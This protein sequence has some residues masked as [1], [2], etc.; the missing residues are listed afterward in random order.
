MTTA[1]ATT[2]LA[3]LALHFIS[4][5][6]DDFGCKSETLMMSGKLNTNKQCTREMAACNF[7]PEYAILRR[8]QAIISVACNETVSNTATT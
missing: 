2:A 8:D 4:K 7:F 3:S 5:G 1:S 6:D